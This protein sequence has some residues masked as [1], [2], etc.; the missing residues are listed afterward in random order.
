MTCDYWIKLLDAKRAEITE[1]HARMADISYLTGYYGA[2]AEQSGNAE[3]RAL[4]AEL[5]DVID[6]TWDRSVMT[7]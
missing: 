5:R 2:K 4:V 6:G 3:L 1:Q 7:E